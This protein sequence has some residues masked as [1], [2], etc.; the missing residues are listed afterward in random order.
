M[1]KQVS[2]GKRERD[3]TARIPVASSSIDSSRLSCSIRSLFVGKHNSLD[4]EASPLCTS[5]PL[6]HSAEQR[7]L[8]RRPAASKENQPLW[9]ESKEL[10]DVRAAE[11]WQGAGISQASCQTD[12]SSASLSLEPP[13]Q[14]HA[15][16]VFSTHSSEDETDLQQHLASLD[17]SL[18][19]SASSGAQAGGQRSPATIQTPCNTPQKQFTACRSL[20]ETALAQGMQQAFR[21]TTATP[22]QAPKS[23]EQLSGRTLKKV[24]QLWIAPTKQQPL[25]LHLKDWDLPAGVVQV[26]VKQG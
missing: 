13:S 1:V 24:Q 12:L 19:G 22:L 18:P 21:N 15:A 6:Y 23:T 20:P 9:A 7:N 3:K 17:L 16:R 2:G 14:P 11:S 5:Q 4:R 26:W 25:R 8:V 10:T